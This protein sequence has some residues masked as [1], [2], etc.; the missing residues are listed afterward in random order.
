MTVRHQCGSATTVSSPGGSGTGQHPGS[1]TLTSYIWR[2]S[3]VSLDPGPDG[4]TAPCGFDV[5]T[6]GLGAQ[7]GVD[8]YVPGSGG[9]SSFA[10]SSRLRPDQSTALGALLQARRDGVCDKGNPGLTN[11]H[12]FDELPGHAAAG[13]V[14]IYEKDYRVAGLSLSPPK[15]YLN[16]DFTNSSAGFPAALRKLL[17]GDSFSVYSGRRTYRGTNSQ[18]AAKAAASVRIEFTRVR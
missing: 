4:T 2:D 16:G 10:L 11:A 1:A 18:T 8:A 9:G 15:T 17:R 7:I 3:V 12:V 6:A 5:A 14:P 13:T